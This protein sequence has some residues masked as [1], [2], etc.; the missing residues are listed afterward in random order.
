MRTERRG[1]RVRS[2][3][4]SVAEIEC[5][6]ARYR[7]RSYAIVAVG[8]HP[9]L[10]EERGNR[11]K[12]K[13]EGTGEWERREKKKW[14]VRRQKREYKTIKFLQHLSVSLQICNNIVTMLYN[15]WDLAHLINLHFCVWCGKCAKYLTF[16]T[17][18]T[19]AMDALTHSQST[20]WS[21]LFRVVYQKKKKKNFLKL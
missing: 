8:E 20:K 4:S 13:R 18:A 2:A 9:G 1:K 21:E 15:F 10:V 12:E 19:P 3:R 5:G 16:G 7:C 6:G 17:C 14:R 11:Y